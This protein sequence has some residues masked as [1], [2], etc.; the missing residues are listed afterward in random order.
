MTHASHERS[1]WGGKRPG[2]GAPRGN[3]NGLKHG[4]YSKQFARIGALLARDPKIR[5]ALLDIARRQQIRN[6]RSNEVAAL[7]LTRFFQRARQASGKEL[8]LTAD[9]H[10]LDAINEAAA[11]AAIRQ[12]QA[13][14]RRANKNANLPRSNQIPD[15]AATT[16]STESP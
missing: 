6:E 16:Q 7:L 2:A 12:I 4:L 15:T 1:R 9:V 10:A 13:A 14:A 3:L 5:D 8:N 11:R